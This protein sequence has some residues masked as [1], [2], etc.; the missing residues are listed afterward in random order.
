MKLRFYD[1]LDAIFT[2]IAGIL[3]IIFP[4]TMIQ[5]IGIIL[6]VYFA[7]RAVLCYF[8]NI[9]PFRN[10]L[11]IFN[12]FFSVLTFVFWGFFL[13]FMMFIFGII[14]TLLGLM[15]LVN[16]DITKAKKERIWNILTSCV[17]LLG[18]IAIICI[19]F[20]NAHQVLGIVT[21]AI[22]IFISVLLFIKNMDKHK[23][24]LAHEETLENSTKDVIDAEI[25]SETTEDV[26][27]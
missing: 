19:S 15:K 9:S 11:V 18:G 13:K 24:D 14:V 27:D 21:G 16:Q 20:T 5:W 12:I 17:E 22:L 26:H 2:L 25:V 1:F 10:T 7:L 8:F 6:G 3:F 23:W 4:N